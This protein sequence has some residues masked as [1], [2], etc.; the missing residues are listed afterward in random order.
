MP[1]LMYNEIYVSGY[2]ADVNKYIAECT[3]DGYLSFGKCIPMPKKWQPRNPKNRSKKAYA[4]R[5]E[6]WGSG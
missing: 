3:V 5:Q 4:W 6:H 2:A 1:S